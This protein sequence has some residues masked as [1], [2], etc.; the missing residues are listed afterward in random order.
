MAQAIVH[1][2]GTVKQI[3]EGLRNSFKQAVQNYEQGNYFDTG[4]NLGDIGST[5]VPIGFVGFGATKLTYHFSSAA[6]KT[7]VQGL[8]LVTRE[9]RQF[10]SSHRLISPIT[11]RFNAV[12]LNSRV[13]F[14]AI[15][16]KTSW[17][18]KDVLSEKARLRPE[19]LLNHEEV[20]AMIWQTERLEWMQRIGKADLSKVNPMIKKDLK[21]CLNQLRN[22]MTPD[23]FSAILKEQ[24]GV[25]I[26]TSSSG[27]YQHL[28]EEWKDVQLSF[29]NV[30]KGPWNGGLEEA[31]V[32]NEQFSNIS[33]LWNRFEKLIER[34]KCSPEMIT[35]KP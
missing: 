29:R 14:D 4:R 31:A 18:N 33:R 28:N 24:R 15:K 21:K 25:Q 16:L 35:L 27:K 3:S 26:S 19:P 8:K 17:T 11:F 2:E 7:S 32:L 22:H 1:Y 34:A 12:R 23:D 6:A 30:L 20:L 5:V 10:I 9:T 13:S